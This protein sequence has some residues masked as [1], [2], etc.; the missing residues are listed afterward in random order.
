MHMHVAAMRTHVHTHSMCTSSH[1]QLQQKGDSVQTHTHTYTPNSLKHENKVDLVP[2]GFSFT[3]QHNTTPPNPHPKD[4]H[5][6]TLVHTHTY[7]PPY[8]L[9][10][11]LSEPVLIPNEGPRLPFVSWRSPWLQKRDRGGGGNW[12]ERGLSDGENERRGQ[13]QKRMWCICLCKRRKE[14]TDD[15]I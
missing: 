4:A 15:C 5:T 11:G 7:T 12:S 10:S 13:M 8:W 9:L 3:A 14:K 2:G 6:R 1:T